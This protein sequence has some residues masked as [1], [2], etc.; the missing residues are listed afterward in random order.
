VSV[1]QGCTAR[2]LGTGGRTFAGTVQ[3]LSPVLSKERRSLRVLF[4]IDDRDGLLRPG[5]FA[6]IG[7]GTDSREALIVPMAGVVHVGHADY[8]LVRDGVEAWTIAEVQVG[9]LHGDSVEILGG[10]DPGDQVV[11]QGAILL[12][13]LVVEAAQRSSLNRAGG[14]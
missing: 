1:G 2:F 6:D 12:K 13:P 10:I 3:S 11:G 14:A 5:M 7:L 4:T 8:L 9:E